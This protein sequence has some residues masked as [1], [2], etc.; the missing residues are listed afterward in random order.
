MKFFIDTANIEEIREAATWGILSGVTTNPTLAAREGRD[1]GQIIEEIVGL[2]NGPISAE[3]ISLDAQQILPEARQ[4][5]A[6][7]DNIVVKIPVTT[8]G[9]AATKI[10]S[11]E[12]IRVN[13]TLVFTVNQAL[14]AAEAGAAYVSP[15][16]GRLD[17]IGEDGIALLADL[18]EVYNNYDADTEIIAASIRHP[19]HV[20]QAALIGVD[21]ATI[22]FAVLKKMVQHPLTEKGIDQFLAD[23]DKLQSVVEREKAGDQPLANIN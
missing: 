15:F 2:V 4:L 7:S 16:L 19:Q 3:A 10:L 14:M 20:T 6:I 22:P 18:V 9:L 5:A 12:G 1:F 8:E 23:W 17:D 13:M 11:G 21:I